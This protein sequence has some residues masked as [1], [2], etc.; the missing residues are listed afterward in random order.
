MKRFKNKFF[1]GSKGQAMAEFALTIPVFFM[2]VLGVIELSRFF[3]VYSSVF[4]AAREASRYGSA[5]GVITREIDGSDVNFFRYQD[6][7]GIVDAAIRTGSFAGI[8]SDDVTVIYE[9]EPGLPDPAP[10]CDVNSP[11]EATMGDRVKVLVQ[12]TYEPIVGIVPEITVSSENGR[13]IMMAITK[14]KEPEPFDLCS[15]HVGFVDAE[16][17]ES[18]D[19]NVLFVELENTSADAAFIIYQIKNVSWD[20]SA[21]EPKLVEIRWSSEANPIWISDPVEGSLPLL[22]I[23]DAGSID[24]WKEFNRNLAP[25]GTEML[26]FVFD[27]EVDQEDI[28]LSFELIM[29]HASLPTDFCDPVE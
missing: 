10:V 14:Q 26:E 5:N 17:Q 15:E 4:T 11:Y 12:S 3:L 23:P 28:N 21:D 16:P 7:I 22:T 13:T 8:S 18:A 27:Q 24:Y 1:G 6:C 29:Q 9:T 2:L 20:V 19:V 25:D